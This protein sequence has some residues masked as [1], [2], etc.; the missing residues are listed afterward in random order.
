MDATL[1]Y[2]LETEP[3]FKIEHHDKLDLCGGS[4]SRFRSTWMQT[5]TLF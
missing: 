4:R 3:R 1:D 5:L 2:I